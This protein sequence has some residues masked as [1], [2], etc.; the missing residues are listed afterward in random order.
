MAFAVTRYFNNLRQMKRAL[1]NE[2]VLWL[3][4]R[5]CKLKRV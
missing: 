1:E 5:L 2:P 3:Y 4:M